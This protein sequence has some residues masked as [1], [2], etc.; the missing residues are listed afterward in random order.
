MEFKGRAGDVTPAAMPE[1]LFQIDQNGNRF[2]RGAWRRRRGMRHS[3]LAAQ[4]DTLLTLA[5]M[6]TPSGTFALALV[7]GVNVRGFSGVTIQAD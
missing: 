5:G 6:E 1:G 3:S 2:L 7:E 4:S